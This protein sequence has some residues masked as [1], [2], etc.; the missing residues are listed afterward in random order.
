MSGGRM[1]IYDD[2]E[3]KADAR[4]KQLFETIKNNDALK[5]MF[6]KRALNEANDLNADIDYLFGFF[7]GS[8]DSWEQDSFMSEGSKEYGKGTFTMH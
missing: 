1:Q 6:S 7:K 3:K 4:V 2:R 5:A 8:V